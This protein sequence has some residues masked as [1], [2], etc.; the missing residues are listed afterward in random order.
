MA[1]YVYIYEAPISQNEI[2]GIAQRIRQNCIDLVHERIN[3]TDKQRK[4]IDELDTYFNSVSPKTM[5]CIRHI[6][7]RFYE[8]WARMFPAKPRE[9]I[10]VVF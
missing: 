2:D 5:D 4:L 7:Q 1:S 10:K 8:K 3:D 9:P 6:Q